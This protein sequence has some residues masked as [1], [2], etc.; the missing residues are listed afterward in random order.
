[1]T[2]SRNRYAA[3]LDLAIA[4]HHSVHTYIDEFACVSDAPW[5]QSF[6]TSTLAYLDAQVNAWLYLFCQEEKETAR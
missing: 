1:M 3:H 5:A 4:R 6:L 2:R